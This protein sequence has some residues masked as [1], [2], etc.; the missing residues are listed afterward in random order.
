[1]Y[2]YSHSVTPAVRTHMDAQVSFINDI[3]KSLFQSFQQLCDLNIQLTQTMLEEATQT[4]QQLLTADRQTDILGAAASRAQPATE[5]LRAYQQHISRVAA[6]AQVQLARVTE[7]HVQETTRTAR[8][9]ADE[10]QRVASE[11]TDRSMRNQQETMRKFTDPFMQNGSQRGNG[12][13]DLRGGASMQSGQ[14]GSAQ[15][16][17]V[18]GSQSDISGGMQ[19]ASHGSTGSAGTTTGSA[20]GKGTGGAGKNT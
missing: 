2:P 7:Q 6:D 17:S 8:A 5:K 3:S 16:S 15:G 4:G 11:E 13:S 19:S 18:G 9:L 20:S 12:S 14:P 10:V 1:M